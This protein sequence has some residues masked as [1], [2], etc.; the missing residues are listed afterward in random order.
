MVESS[1]F[2]S[3][4]DFDVPEIHER[5]CIKFG[6]KPETNA[7]KTYEMIKTTIKDD[8]LSHSKTFDW[9]KLFKNSRQS[10]GDD[11]R[12]GRLFIS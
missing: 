12:S 9:F 4:G 7:T 1:Q 11:L 5:V 3:F 10:T 8:S 2:V 6:F